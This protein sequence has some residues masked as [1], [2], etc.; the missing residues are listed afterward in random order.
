M[1]ATLEI[2]DELYRRV[3]AKSALEGRP[4]REVAV[5]LLRGYVDS[6]LVRDAD[7]EGAPSPESELVDGEPVPSWFG[8]FRESAQ[9]VGRHG[10]DEIRESIAR[11][12]AEDRDR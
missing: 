7:K 9:R 11:G 5:E 4:V 2:P 6:P 12:I 8:T 3:K 10:L 1:K